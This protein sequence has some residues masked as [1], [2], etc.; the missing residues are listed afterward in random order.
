MIR[1]TS[2]FIAL[3]AILGFAA[4]EHGV[5]FPIT[6]TAVQYTA[7]DNYYDSSNPDIVRF[8]YTPTKTGSCTISTGYVSSSFRRYLYYYG[9]KDTFSGYV[10]YDYDNYTASVSFK[11]AAGQTYYLAVEVYYSS[12]YSYSFDIKASVTP[13]AIVSIKG[14]A[15]PDTVL[16]NSS[17]TIKAPTVKAG[18]RF[19]NWNIETGTGSFANSKSISTTFTPKS[20]EVELSYD[21]EKGEVYPLTD[22]YSSFTHFTNASMTGDNIYGVRTSYKASASGTFAIV[23]KS[24]RSFTLYSYGTDSEFKTRASSKSVSSSVNRS[25]FTLTAG[26]SYYFVLSQGTYS[27]FGDT[28]SAKV[29]KTL[30]VTSDTVG[31]G[32]V[33]VGTGSLSYDSSYVAKDTVPI[34]AV[35]A[36]NTRFSKWEKVSGTCTILNPNVAQTKVVIESDCK[37]RATFVPGTVYSITTTPKTYTPAEHYYSGSPSNGVRFSFVAPEDGWYIVNCAKDSSVWSYMYRYKTSAFSSY[38]TYYN[39]K[40][41]IADTV[42]LMAGDSLFYLVES[43]YSSDSLM[44][45]SMSYEKMPSLSLIVESASPQC[46]TS[47]YSKSVLKGMK[48]SIQAYA[49]KGY[50]PD[51]WTFVTGQHK[52]SDSSAYLITTTIESDTKIKLGC[53]AAN[54]IELTDK[55]QKYVAENDFYEQTPSSGMRFY[56]KTPAKGLYAFRFVPNGFY[57]T[58]RYYAGDSTFSTVK[59][60]YGSTS[61][62]YTFFVPS[63]AAGEKFYL[64]AMPYSSTYWDKTI[65]VG[66]LP[67]GTVKVS[68]KSKVDTLAYGDSLDITAVLDTGDHF[69]KWSI[70]SGKGRFVDASLYATQYIF[71]STSELKPVVSKLPLYEIV[72]Q[73]KGYTY[74][75]N[76]SNNKNLNY[77]VRMYFNPTVSGTYSIR[78]KG[79]NSFYL[80]TY[81]TDSTFYN[82]SRYTCSSGICRY[83]ITVPAGEKRYFQLVPYTAA[84]VED[85]VWIRAMKT[86]SLRADTSGVGY[87]YVGTST[88]DYDSTYVVGDTVPIRAFTSAA[89]FKFKKWSVASGSCKILDSTR[90]S[91]YIIPSGD[92]TV[93][94]EFGLGTVYPIENVAKKYIPEENYYSRSA[95]YGVR[96][97]FVAPSDGEYTFAFRSIDMSMTIE[98]YNSRAFNSYIT[99]TTSVYNRFDP[100]TLSA[101]DSVFYIVRSSYSS[102]TTDA[103]WVSYSQSK[104]NIELTAEGNGSVSPSSGYT[105]AWS[106][107]AYP[108]TASAQT[109]YRFDRWV[110]VSGVGAIDDTLNYE[111]VVYATKDSKIKAIFNKGNIYE[112]TKTKETYSFKKHHYAD[113][114]KKTVYYSWNPTDTNYYMIAI[115]SVNGSCLHYGADSLFKTSNTK[116]ILKGTSYVLIKGEPGKKQYFAIT[117]SLYSN[118]RDEFAIQVISPKHLFV[119]SKKGRTMPSGDV[120][121]PPGVDTLVYAVPYGGY[122]FESWT[123]VT[124]NV[125]IADS[126]KSSTRVEPESDY[127][128]IRANYVLDSATVP[129]V[130]ITNLDLSNHPGICAHVSVVDE[131]TGKPIVG[132]DSSDFVLFQ[133]G[134]NLPAQTTT[135]QSVGGVSVALVVDESGSMDGSR[136]IKAKDAIRQFINEMGPYDR[137]A[138]VGF[139]GYSETQVHQS[140]TSDKSLLLAAVDRLTSDGW[141]TNINTGTR[142]GVRQVEGETNP[143]AVIVFSDGK[144]LDD[145]A[146]TEEVLELA[147]T[148][149]TT[150]YSIGLETRETDPLLPLAEGSG[151][152]YT[153]APDASQLTGI[154]STIRGTVQERYVLCYQ[155]PDAVWDGDTHTVVI[156]TDFLNKDARDT[157]FWNE[158]FLPPRV[159]LTDSTWKLV[160]VE[161][162]E[163]KSIKIS[164][165]VTSKDSIKNVNLFMKKTSLTSTSFKSYPM[166]HVKDSLWT[167]T[168]PDSLVTYPGVDFYV[169]ATDSHGLSGRTPA[170]ANPSKQ[171]YT[172]PVKNQVPVIVMDSLKCLDMKSGSGKLRFT[173][174]DK[175]GVHDAT[176]YYKDS[177]AVLFDEIALTKN[178]NYWEASIPATAFERGIGEIYVRAVDGVGGSV[179]WPKKENTWVPVCG[180]KVYVPDVKDVVTIVNKES[181]NSPIGR[182][183]KYV[184]ITV[185]TEDFT[186]YVDTINVKLSCLASGDVESKVVL[187]EKKEGYFESRDTLF[188]NEYAPKKDDGKISCAARDT[189]V[190]E[191]K[192]PLFDTYT[193]DTVFIRDTV[194]YSYRFL[195][196]KNDKDLDSVETGSVA[197]FRIRVTA[198]SESIH[199]VDTLKVLLYTDGKDS[200]WVKAVETGVYTST[201]EYTGSFHFVESKSDLKSSELDAVFDLKTSRNRVKIQ[202]WIKGDSSSES[203]RDSLIVFSNYVPADYA[204]IYDID[205]DGKADSIRIRFISPLKADLEGVDTLYWNKAGGT[206][207]SVAKK[208]LRA[209]D[210]RSW[211]EAKLE[212]PFEYGATAADADNTP[213]LKLAKTKDGFAQK[214]KI[215]DRIGAVPV[216]AVKH[217]GVIPLDEYLENS[218]A[219]PPD[220]LV[221]TV[222][223]KIKNKGK[224]DAWK[225]LFVYSSSCKDT[226]EKSL[227][228]EK[229]IKKDSTGRVWNFVLKN[230]I[231]KTEDC[232]RTNPKATFEDADGNSM[233]RGGVK[234][235][236]SN[237]DLYLYEVAPVPTVSGADQD[238]EWIA[239]D[240]DEFSDLP[241]SLAAI[242]VVSIMPY[243]ASVVIYDGLSNVV[244]HF[245]QDFG[246]KKGEMTQKVR[247]NSENHAKTGYLTWNKRSKKGRLVGTGVYIW[248][249]DFKFIDGHSEYRLIKTGVKRKK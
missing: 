162:Q 190:A 41:S 34:R 242:R 178:G 149:N 57:G 233:G 197:N 50:R 203:K 22:V 26:E 67:A 223:E 51:G 204:E 187:I 131:R 200:L 239:P 9:T 12:N 82:Y 249:I 231:L 172:I 75:D 205:L 96:F 3:F 109:G 247:G 148:L 71:E 8:S 33:Y 86:V 157:A 91:T 184:G 72:E 245:K 167:Y 92:C 206:W 87:A 140:M 83:L 99:R 165:Y 123:K 128:S 77:G 103:F 210:N 95:T 40:T 105:N 66:A 188:K 74:K 176:L 121:L 58:D 144:N 133:D 136:I 42:S 59:D 182:T 94:A 155:S 171:P 138:I 62:S 56:Y 243:T 49:R 55:L 229:V 104:V 198:L 118:N 156:Q 27:Y 166:T 84:N 195:E 201:F 194:S 48:V 238:A 241:D 127:C 173:I 185:N 15:D 227:N 97:S 43:E 5:V 169:V 220:T 199:N 4:E 150:I 141:S 21:T 244:T 47:T 116:T 168:I 246:K 81:G 29:V 2:L 106:G 7:N 228:I 214:V 129:E 218:V 6:E 11:C 216:E 234:V 69:V 115:D 98:R 191:Y 137:T 180:R 177:L 186:D 65:M 111:T 196:P 143:T 145:D 207:R 226:A 174:T 132:L 181:S 13:G 10:D 163:N 63:S 209:V 237:G 38:S 221:V 215:K 39:K 100:L 119:E 236:G 240:D 164:V 114:D 24:N 53:K 208:D 107:A 153:Y 31:A 54:L 224:D 170:I 19:V 142:T 211:F 219:I 130:K 23:T 52:V 79:E 134:V 235:T 73:F 192:D 212:E 93:K 108:I 88:R 17:L 159:D 64:S 222:S 30:K 213:Y 189:M 152:T 28:I 14:K 60:Y 160:G 175:D 122:I 225:S 217:P 146:T 161:Q 117:D 183:T 89:D 36:S 76:G 68:G 102:D 44:K 45:F 101:G 125:K 25:V 230:H 147:K 78:Y 154:Y 112:L 158:D 232:I 90:S 35:S 179:R 120:Y 124:G 37:V 20:E 16:L 18:D 202:S 151:G 1:L 248:R 61:Y 70:V 113:S 85:S 80:F 126:T 135:I 46:S 139:T 110:Y 193:R 32:K